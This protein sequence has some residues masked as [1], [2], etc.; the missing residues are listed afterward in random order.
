MRLITSHYRDPEPVVCQQF[1]WLGTSLAWFA[2]APG[3][4]GE[5]S[6]I[7]TNLGDDAS[8]WLRLWNTASSCAEQFYQSIFGDEGLDLNM[9]RYNVGGGN[10]SD[11]AYGY[12]FMR[13]G[14]AVPG[15]WKDDATGSG[16]YGNG[17]TTK[18][19]DKDKLAAAFDPTDDNQY[20]FSKS[21]AQDW[22]IERGATGR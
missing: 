19:A 15:T 3:S 4:L 5:E 2:N 9:A 1:R 16:T 10:A 22:W 11:V 13:Q 8:K 18:Q 21:A 6:A 20:D 17:V 7:T 12:P 14:A